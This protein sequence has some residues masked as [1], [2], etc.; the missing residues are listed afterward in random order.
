MNNIHASCVMLAAAARPFGA[1]ED[2][3]V[4]ILGESGAGK[5]GL[6]LRL[7]AAGA[8]L[9]ADD[10]VELFSRADALW[11]KPPAQLAGLIEARGVGI[12]RLPHAVEARVALAV[13]LVGRDRVPRLPEPAFF[14]PPGE[15]RQENW[16]PLLHLSAEDPA[17][18]AKIVLAAAAFAQTLYY[19]TV[20]YHPDRA[21]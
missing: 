16:P 7:L 12:V 6:A 20:P 1:A 3:G 11:A 8:R 18:P 10:R 13:H 17:T 15:I 19:E 2:A 14:A 5:S 21:R 4:L 9:V